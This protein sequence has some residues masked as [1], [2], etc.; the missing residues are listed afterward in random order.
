MSVYRL[1]IDLRSYWHPGGGRGRGAVLDAVTHRDSAGLPVLPGRHLKGLLRDALE[2]ADE[3]GWDGFSGL[4]NRLFGERST[5]DS[6]PDPGV[7]R[8][9]DGELPAP[10]RAWLRQPE[11]RSRLVPHLYRAL[12]ATAVDP[13][14]GTAKD[15]T[16]R[17]I[18]V[19]VPVQLYA[20][21]EP[22]PG[23]QE[24]PAAWAEHLAKA[25]PLIDAIGALRTR[26]L[27]R[28]VLTLTAAPAE[29]S[30]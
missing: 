7:I 17:G 1:T 22:I 26:G 24:A 20:V 8:V 19:V 2:R 18:E 23:R 28:A 9:S 27:G 10:M 11:Q 3:F 4:A 29:E 13:M 21:L 14:S 15:K 30:D 25:L 6:P 5:P 12:Y 16:L